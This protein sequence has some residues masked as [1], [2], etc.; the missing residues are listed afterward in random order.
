M[1]WTSP[2]SEVAIFQYRVQ[3]RKSETALWKNHI[4]IPPAT[5]A[6]ITDLDADT[7]YSVRVRAQSD[8]GSGN[9]SEEQTETTYDSE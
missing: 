5:S 8:V 9:W 6:D 7:D 2:Q 4:I 3:Y 1:N